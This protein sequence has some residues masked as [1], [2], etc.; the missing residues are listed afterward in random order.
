MLLLVPTHFGGSKVW[1]DT[2]DVKSTKMY[3]I[4]IFSHYP[5]NKKVIGKIH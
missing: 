2:I 3:L 1:V 4:Y 5:L